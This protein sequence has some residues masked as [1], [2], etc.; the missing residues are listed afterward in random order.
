MYARLIYEEKQ[1]AVKATIAF[2][3]RSEGPPSLY[4]RAQH[5]TEPVQCSNSPVAN[6]FLK[7][8]GKATQIPCGNISS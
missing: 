3:R 8:I 7:V 4:H 6:N 1:E 5:V 2:G